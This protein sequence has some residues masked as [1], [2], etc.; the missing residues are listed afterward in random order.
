MA[1]D[2]VYLYTHIHTHIT[3]FTQRS[4]QLLHHLSKGALFYDFGL[5]LLQK[6]YKHENTFLSFILSLLYKYIYAFYGLFHCQGASSYFRATMDVSEFDQRVFTCG[7]K[8][9][10]YIYIYIHEIYCEVNLQLPRREKVCFR[11]FSVI[12]SM[13]AQKKIIQ[14]SIVHG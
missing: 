6:L 8:I 9:T 13:H 5:V 10:I 14:S 7:K 2:P 3:M 12:I 11:S 4:R 1:Y